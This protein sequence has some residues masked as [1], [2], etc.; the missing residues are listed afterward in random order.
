MGRGRNQPPHAAA[1]AAV[2]TRRTT[3]RAPVSDYEGWSADADKNE[4]RIHTAVRSGDWV[5]GAQGTERPFRARSGARLLWCW[6]PATGEHQYLNC[7]TDVILTTEES[8]AHMGEHTPQRFERTELAR[9]RMA[10]AVR[11][12]MLDAHYRHL[13]RE[14]FGPQGINAVNAVNAAS[15]GRLLDTA[16]RQRGS[17]QG[18]DRRELIGLGADERV[19]R[20][21]ARYLKVVCD[22]RSPRGPEFIAVIA[23]GATPEPESESGTESECVWDVMA[24]PPRQPLTPPSESSNPLTAPGNGDPFS[25]VLGNRRG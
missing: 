22:G 25:G 23:L 11:P 8:G 3:S 4:A 18:D 1:D 12:P 21:D 19:L 13:N 14:R 20:D 24:G 5:P 15:I 17:L 6:R 9:K 16:I 7:D 2:V 10:E